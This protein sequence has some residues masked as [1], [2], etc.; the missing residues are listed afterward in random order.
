MRVPETRRVAT[1]V[2]RLS[3]RAKAAPMSTRPGRAGRPAVWG[4]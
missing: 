1:R 2:T 4:G 3:S